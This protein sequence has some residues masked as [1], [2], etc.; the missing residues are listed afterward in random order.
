[1]HRYGSVI[2][3]GGTVSTGQFVRIGELNFSTGRSSYIA[4]YMKLECVLS[5]H[6]L[7][8]HMKSEGTL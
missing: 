6:L 1:M 5:H 7:L 8:L 2:L 4:L 3:L